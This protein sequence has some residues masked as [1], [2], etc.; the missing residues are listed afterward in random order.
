MKY[1][2]SIVIML[3]I[4]IIWNRIFLILQKKKNL[5]DYDSFKDKR[6]LITGVNGFVGSHLSEKLVILETNCEIYVI[7]RRQTVPIFPNI[8]N[9]VK[10]LRLYEA[11]KLI[12][13][14]LKELLTRFNPITYFT[15]RKNLLFQLLSS[16][17]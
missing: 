16:H 7:V 14:P 3:S 12:L 1:I 6:V 15:L 13:L 11:I 2:K 10:D 9:I 8:R 4:H 17:Q 5:F